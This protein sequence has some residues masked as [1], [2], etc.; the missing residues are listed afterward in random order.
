[1]RLGGG[2]DWGGEKASSQ[3]PAGQSS[4]AEGQQQ[5]RQRQGAG[6]KSNVPLLSSPSDPTMAKASEQ[7]Q[8]SSTV[9][10]S[11]VTTGVGLAVLP[12]SQAF[13]SVNFVDCFLSSDILREGT[14]KQ[15][16]VAEALSSFQR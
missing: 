8:P 10:G 14:D 9:V 15:A 5:Q 16:N 6:K 3:S 2:A 12:I 1:M 7:Q 11:S 13:D 4:K